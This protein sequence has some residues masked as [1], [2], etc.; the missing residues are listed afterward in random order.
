M[1]L[2]WSRAALRDLSEIH[3]YVS[4]DSAHQADKLIRELAQSAD[5]LETFPRS[6]RVVPEYEE[7]DNYC[8]LVVGSYRVIHCVE[9]ST[10]D[11]VAVIHGAKM[12]P[13][14]PP[15]FE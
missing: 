5:R 6:G 4:Q 15:E 7:H 2:R 3:A 8:E 12:L 11:V 10:V 13:G 1:K 9:A 14:E